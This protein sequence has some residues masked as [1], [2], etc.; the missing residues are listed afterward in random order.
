M[1][2]YV[3]VKTGAPPVEVLQKLSQDLGSSWKD[4]GRMLRI[5][6]AALNNFDAQHSSYREKGYQ[7]LLC[8]KG[9]DGSDATYQVLN[10]ALRDELVQQTILAEEFCSK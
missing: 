2:L 7:M 6:E 10:D 9:R 5:K 3:A 4:L 1:E 8:W